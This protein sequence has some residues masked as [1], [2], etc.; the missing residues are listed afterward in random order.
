MLCTVAVIYPAVLLVEAKNNIYA[1]IYFIG[2]IALCMKFTYFGY[3]AT[4]LEGSPD[5][6]EWIIKKKPLYIIWLG[7]G[8]FFLTV[9]L[10]KAIMN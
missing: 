1:L 4:A 5:S 6:E 8:L 9:V 7:A 3:E 10:L 2:S